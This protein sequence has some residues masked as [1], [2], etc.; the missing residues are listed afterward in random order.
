MDYVYVI[1]YFLD[2]CNG[3]SGILGIV[4]DYENCCKVI[5]NIIEDD[6]I[7]DDNPGYK[8][9]LPD[10]NEFNNLSIGEYLVVVDITNNQNYYQIEK[11]Q[12]NKHIYLE[13]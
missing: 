6:N 12:F 10:I 8:F 4:E 2:E 5:E 13:P 7:K 9:K 3:V 1:K 11:C